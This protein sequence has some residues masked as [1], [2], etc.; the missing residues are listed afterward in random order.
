MDDASAS[1]P[2]KPGDG[3]R[4]R[5]RQR[6][7]E[8]CDDSLRDEALLELL[9]SYAIVRRDIQPLAKSLLVKFGDLDGVLAAD[10]AVLRKT[11]GIKDTTIALLKF[12]HHLRES[13]HDRSPTGPSPSKVST[14]SE[15][16]NREPDSTGKEEP[17]SSPAAKA[18][19]RRTVG[20][21]KLQVSNGYLLE[22]AQLAR[23]LE[24]IQGKPKAR[25]IASAELVEGSGLSARQVESLVS[26]GSA[27]GLITPRTQLLTPFGTLVARHD[28]FIDSI[29]TL[30]LCH[31]LAAGSERNLAWFEIFNE[32]LPTQRSLGQAAWSAWL[33]Q[34][35]AGQYAERSLV[36]HVGHE[37]RFVLDAYLIRN[38]KKLN[39]LTQTPEKTFAVRRYSA[40]QPLSLAAMIYMVG[41]RSGTR[42]VP[43][44]DLHGRH[45]SPGRVF[46]PPDASEGLP[47]PIVVGT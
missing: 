42:L 33:R 24:F 4:E 7:L 43:F 30:E 8:G 16:S 46:A 41:A 12:A 23:L 3:H 6:F 40:L 38:F 32:M 39:L 37:V 34:K 26:I 44:A 36:K 21:R 20:E 15:L 22:T 1:P 14:P 31:F 28:I 47:A 19:E 17:V 13:K 29:T 45:G 18:S 27:L 2:N 9:L 25:K 5:L 35:L 11:S 10:A